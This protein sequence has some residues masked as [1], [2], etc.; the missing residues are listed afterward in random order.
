MQDV[1]TKVFLENGAWH[2]RYVNDHGREMF[3][4]CASEAM[5]K[6][7]ASSLGKSKRPLPASA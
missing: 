7:L 3:F 1:T 4:T 2:V 6:N 5:A